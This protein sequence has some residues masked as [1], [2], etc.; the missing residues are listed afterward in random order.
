MSCYRPILLFALSCGM[1]A[2]QRLPVPH[3]PSQASTLSWKSNGGCVQSSG[4]S[5]E[6]EA[7][8]NR[9]ELQAILGH[10][11]ITANIHQPRLNGS[12]LAAIYRACTGRRVIVSSAAE[13]AEFSLVQ[14]AS[15]QNP[16]PH[17]LMKELIEKSAIIEGFAFIPDGGTPNLDI[18][19]LTKRGIRCSPQSV[20]VFTE[21][22]PLPEGDDVISYIMTLKYLELNE[23]VAI[24]TKSVGESCPYGSIVAMPNASCIIATQRTSIVRKL[25]TLQKEIDKPLKGPDNK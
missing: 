19:T 23:A 16:I 7:A 17:A 8:R 5:S 22:T 20:P 1:V 4:N 13:T 2:G 11:E 18:L 15:P 9:A 21:E 14:D 6:D 3:E 24:F 12:T 10:K 25:V